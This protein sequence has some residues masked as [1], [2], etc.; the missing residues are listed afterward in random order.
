MITNSRTV[1]SQR[2]LP[3]IALASLL[4]AFLVE[5]PLWLS[6]A[7]T[8]PAGYQ[9]ISSLV[10]GRSAFTS[11]GAAYLG[12]F[13]HIAVSLM[14]AAIY[15][16]LASRFSPATRQPI[17]YGALYGLLVYVVM[18]SAIALSGSWQPLTALTLAI[19]LV[20]HVAFFGIPVA[21]VTA[22]KLRGA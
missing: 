19:G 13:L 16:V 1:S 6:G 12:V 18:Q 4:S 15:V 5:I 22:A 9:W 20:D 3:I 17:V 11:A 2:L 10:L 8:W 21:L 14:W 7:V